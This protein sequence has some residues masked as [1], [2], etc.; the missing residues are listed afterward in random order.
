LYVLQDAKHALVQLYVVLAPQDII[1]R[2]VI[3]KFVRLVSV[4][5]VIQQVVWFVKLGIICIRHHQVVNNVQL[6][7]L[8]VQEMLLVDY[9]L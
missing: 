6:L 5:H 1:Y 2:Q 3:V 8:L 4:V 7:A 9:V